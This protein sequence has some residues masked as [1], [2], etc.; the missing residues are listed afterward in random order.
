MITDIKAKSGGT[1]LIDHSRAV[2]EY[3]RDLNEE[4]FNLSEG[5]VTFLC[6][7]HDIGKIPKPFQK[8]L[9][10]ENNNYDHSDLLR[11]KKYFKKYKNIEDYFP[12][13]CNII[14]SHHSMMKNADGIT[15]N[16]RYPIN[17]EPDP[18]LPRLIEDFFTY[19]EGNYLKIGNIDFS[20]LKNTK[21]VIKFFSLLNAADWLA[22]GGLRYPY[23]DFH[24]SDIQGKLKGHIENFSQDSVIN[25][26]RSNFYEACLEDFGNN[27]DSK[28]FI[29]HGNTGIGKFL[30]S[31]TSATLFNKRIIYVAPYNSILSQASQE[32]NNILGSNVLNHYSNSEIDNVSYNSGELSPKISW[33]KPIIVTSYVQL[34]ESIFCSKKG[35]TIKN[36]SLANSVIILD[37]IQSLPIKYFKVLIN[38][39]QSLDGCKVIFSSA[40]PMTNFL[41]NS[42]EGEDEIKVIPDDSGLRE[43]IDKYFTKNIK[44]EIR[45]EDDMEFENF[46]ENDSVLY[47]RNSVKRAEDLYEYLLKFNDSKDVYLLTARLVSEDRNKVIKDVVARLKKEEPIKLVATALVEAGINF[48]FDKGVR[49]IAGLDR[50]VQFAGRVKRSRRDKEAE[51]IVIDYNDAGSGSDGP[52]KDFSVNIELTRKFIKDNESINNSTLNE[53]TQELMNKKGQ[54]DTFSELLN[55]G[56]YEKLREDIKMIDSKTLIIKNKL[57]DEKL[58]EK[59]KQ[60]GKIDIKELKEIQKNSISVYP[61]IVRVCDD[62]KEINIKLTSNKDIGLFIFEGDYDQVYGARICL[63]SSA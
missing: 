21:N 62:V 6:F 20:Q 48:D 42:I 17:K 58:K 53:Y 45:Q 55:N 41:N 33:D 8:K 26:Y 16:K 5:L 34:I 60:S 43:E 54:E 38:Y 14:S 2:V 49:D 57:N 15:L 22:S 51:I 4:S 12:T 23:E 29:L 27:L 35:K 40:T 59:L 25:E 37:E 63:T 7:F 11:F 44:Y 46:G 9:G 3:G 28:F 31:L 36:I 13:I 47:V 56:K 52:T 19:F 30:T 39:L 32:L 24:L 10:G 1:T 18:D 61:Y 50:V